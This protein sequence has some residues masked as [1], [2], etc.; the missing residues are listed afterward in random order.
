MVE[1]Y[2]SERDAMR[3][4]NAIVVVSSEANTKNL[5]DEIKS[6]TFSNRLQTIQPAASVLGASA[7]NVRVSGILYCSV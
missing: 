7:A 2:V 6:F 5:L 1:N 3:S 4:S